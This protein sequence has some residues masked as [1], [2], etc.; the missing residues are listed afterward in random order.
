MTRPFRP[1]VF[2]LHGLLATSYAHFS[3]LIARWRHR[4]RVVPLDLPGHGRC[5]EDA[6]RPYYQ[7]C[8]DYLHARMG[9][10][11]SGHVIGASYLGSSVA[12]RACLAAPARFQSLVLSGY[13]P[14][15]PHSVLHRWT[16]S[17]TAVTERDPE[18][19]DRYEALHGR[20]WRQ[21]LD[22]VLDEIRDVYPTDVAVTNEQLARLQVFTLL[23]NGSLK[24][25]ERTASAEIP[26]LSPYV[27]GGIIPGGG[28]I[29]SYDQ[30]ELFALLVEDFWER[31]ERRSHAANQG[32][33]DRA[34]FA[35]RGEGHDLPGSTR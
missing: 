2:L 17:F 19:V 5:P 6:T 10:I 13:V 11:G 21:T 27:E 12:L 32:R 9:E 15:A 30:P 34:G 25:D 14:Q 4:I 1:T 26:S 7:R 18:L 20:R 33:H 22:T 8:V 28:H 23:L 3:A 24:S 31:L 16:A 29:P 35:T